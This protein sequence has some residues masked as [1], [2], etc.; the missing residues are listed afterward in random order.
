MIKKIKKQKIS[1]KNYNKSNLI[2]SS[3]YIFYKYYHVSKKFGD[4]S[5]KSR[6]SKYS[7]LFE[8]FNGLNNF[9][10]LI[11]KKEE[12]LKKKTNVHDPASD[13]YNELLEI[14]FNEYYYLSYADH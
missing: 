13:L 10:K 14:Y 5:F 9:N 8:F 4:F 12:T 3:K 11:T 2:C 1:F 7:F 6:K